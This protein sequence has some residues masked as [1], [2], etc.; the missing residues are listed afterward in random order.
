M[1]QIKFNIGN[2]LI[3]NNVL[4]QSMSDIKT[5][6]I[7]ENIKLTNFLAERGLDMMRFSILDYD[8]AIALK[9]IKANVNIPIIADIHF[10]YRLALLAMENNVDKIRINPGNIKKDGIYKIIEV[11]KEKH[12][13]IRIGVNSGSLN[14][15]KGKTSSKIDDILLELNETLKIFEDNKFNL[16]VLS[17]KSSDALETYQLYSKASKLYPYPLHIGLT[18]SGFS[19]VGCIKSATCLYPL[20][21]EGIGD[22]IRVSLSND[23]IEEIRAC[24]ELL[25]LANRRT[26]IPEMIVCPG[27]GRTQIQLKEVANEVANYL[28][29]IN[30]NIKVAVMG[31]P[32]NGIGEA[33]D[34]DFTIT[35]NQ[36]LNSYLV[37]V[38]GKII[39]TFSKEEALNKLY[40]LIDEF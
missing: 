39:G 28:D 33:K 40:N 7:N 37:I 36:V 35:G 32:V 27:C 20:L 31:C 6:K 16:L 4:I 38:H 3:G 22:T 19:S 5:S 2:K 17:L 18:E 14:K 11:A 21:V 12:I 34:A 13:P 1:S 24:K 30:K 23:R 15:Y 10:D 9:E 29:K 26:N 8:D 25:R